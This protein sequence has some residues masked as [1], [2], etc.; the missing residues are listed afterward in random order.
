MAGIVAYDSWKYYQSLEYISLPVVV[1]RL[2]ICRIISDQV[3]A[4]IGRV[5]PYF[6]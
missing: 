3:F 4:I 5:Q 1:V 6:I 2:V